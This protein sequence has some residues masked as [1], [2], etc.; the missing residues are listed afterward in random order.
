LVGAGDAG[1]VLREKRNAACPQE[2]EL[3]RELAL[4]ERA[5]GAGDGAAAAWTISASGIIPLPPIP[6]K[7]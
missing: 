6:Q 3:G 1:A 7:K 2:I 5:V 4:V